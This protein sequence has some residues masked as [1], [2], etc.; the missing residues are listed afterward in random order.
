MLYRQKNVGLSI[1][2]IHFF[3]MAALCIVL[4]DTLIFII[5]TKA[6]SIVSDQNKNGPKGARSKLGTGIQL[7]A[8]SNSDTAD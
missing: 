8:R 2:N 7:L 3:G 5:I 4:A 6:Q 1:T